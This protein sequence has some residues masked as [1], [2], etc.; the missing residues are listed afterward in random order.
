MIV[1]ILDDDHSNGTIAGVGAEV[2]AADLH[3]LCRFAP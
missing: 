3:R 2:A 1:P